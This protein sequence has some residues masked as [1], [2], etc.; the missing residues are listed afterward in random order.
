[1]ITGA[2][3]VSRLSKDQAPQVIT[4]F[5]RAGVSDYAD[6]EAALAELFARQMPEIRRD[7]LVVDN[8][9][10]AGVA[11]V[12]PGRTVIGGDNSVWEFSAVD[13]ALAHLGASIW[14]FDLVNVVTSAFRQLYV[15]YLDRFSPELLGALHGVRACV[16]HIDC[17]NDQIRI[18]AY[19]SQHWLRSCFLMLPVAELMVLRTF[20][21]ARHRETWF[22]GRADDP[23]GEA[24]PIDQTYRD[25][26]TG[27]LLGQ[28]IGQGVTWH[29]SLTLDA[30]GLGIFEQKA[31]AIINEHL[32]AIRL[33]AAG[34]RLVDVT[35]LSA[36]LR[37]GLAPL[38]D[39]PWWLQL[40]NRDRDALRV[41]PTHGE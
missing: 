23:F 13:A 16:G 11:E 35:W 14:Q 27:W 6:S 24:S 33:R 4:I 20:V 38:W 5:V 37:E 1:M 21:S 41:F 25:Y 9:L 18:G 10:P 2:P 17:Y 3:T 30:N 7:L 22:S 36:R 40:A 39:T 19:Q 15:A 12:A 31:L 34:C 29:R 28:D 8:L 26:V 32:L